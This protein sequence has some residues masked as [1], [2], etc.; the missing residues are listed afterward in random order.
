MPCHDCGFLFIN[1]KPCDHNASDYK[2]RINGK[3][4]FTQDAVSHTIHESKLFRKLKDYCP[5]QECLIKVVCKEMC[6]KFTE[7]LKW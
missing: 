6:E 5:C 4:I 1:I 2:F 3:V 7:R